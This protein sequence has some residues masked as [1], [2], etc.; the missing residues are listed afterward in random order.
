MTEQQLKERT[1]AFAL[2]IIELVNTIPQDAAG[3]IIEYQ[4][5]RSSTSV[6]ANYRAACRARSKAEF[7]AKLGIV[8]EESDECAYWMELL[9]Q[10]GILTWEPVRAHFE[11]ANAI[12]AIM[13]ASRKSAASRR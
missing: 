9:V 4:L 13:V 8:E 11:E 10:S 1:R 3:R 2:G 12:T 7:I 5:I 6:G